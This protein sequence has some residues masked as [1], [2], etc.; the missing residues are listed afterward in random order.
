MAQIDDNLIK[1][2]VNSCEYIF[3]PSYLMENFVIFDSDTTQQI[4]TVFTDVFEEIILF[5][6]RRIPLK[7]QAIPAKIIY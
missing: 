6:L 4:L 7:V 2:L 3:T 5:T 1:E